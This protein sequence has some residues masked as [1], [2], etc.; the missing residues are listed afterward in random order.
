M[1]QLTFELFDL[2]IDVGDHRSELTDAYMTRQLIAMVSSQIVESV[3]MNQVV[4][5]RW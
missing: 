4:A 2:F 3:V 1:F 5:F